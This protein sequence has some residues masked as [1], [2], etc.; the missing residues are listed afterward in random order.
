MQSKPRVLV[1]G[2]YNR[3][4]HWTE[5][6]VEAFRQAG[7]PVDYFAIN[8]KTRVH[9]HIIRLRGKLAGNEFAAVT[10]GLQRKIKQFSPDL[11]VFVLG[12]WLP[13]SLFE[14]V[15]ATS[16]TS[17]KIAWVGDSF[18]K[19][20]GVYAGYMDSIFCTDTHFID[21]VRQH[22]F[23]T[24]TSYLPLA[25]D[26][27]RF[28]PITVNR[29]DK[30]VY[31]AK[32][33]PE[34]AQLISQIE[35]PLVLYGKKWRR[36][37]LQYKDSPH[38]IHP[39]NLPLN[40]L[41]RLYAASRAVLNIKNEIAVVRG[42]NQRSFEPYGCMTPVLN[43]AVEDISLCFDPGSEILVYRSL[44]ELHEWHDKLT[45]DASFAQK[46]GLAGYRRVM[47]EH[48]YAHRAQTMLKQVGL[49]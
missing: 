43:D 42:V 31:V 15:A 7:C 28:H 12:A 9:S 27:N 33:S 40:R 4:V 3:L 41:P 10:P 2:K 44:D 46:I 38:E 8:G 49:E 22:G 18:D 14:A 16:P 32:N 25:L 24:P 45:A 26:P 35:R 29:T 36:F 19:V 30:I 37:K 5:N 11:V 23:D 47:A 13:A 39:Y 21:L 6:T 48:T 20:Q 34:R 1:V 17:I